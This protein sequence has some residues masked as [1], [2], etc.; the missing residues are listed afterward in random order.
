MFF[1]LEYDLEM[2]GFAA[3]LRTKT[4][5]ENDTM[6][7]IHDLCDAIYWM[8]VNDRPLAFHLTEEELGRLGVDKQ[9]MVYPKFNAHEEETSL[10][11]YHV[12]N[13]FKEFTDILSG[14]LDW[15]KAQFF[16]EYFDIAEHTIFPKFILYSTHA[17]EIAPLLHALDNPLLLHDPPPA[18]AVY[19]EYFEKTRD[20]A[21][22]LRVR[23]FYNADTWYFEHR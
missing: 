7:V 11:T 19:V 15:Q 13:V 18:S 22:E 9:R 17:E 1:E 10:T 4:G 2:S 21:S 12:M 16:T 23:V 3:E 8:I 20:G 5:T 14:N 6:A